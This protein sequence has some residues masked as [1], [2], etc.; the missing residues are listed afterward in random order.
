MESGLS[1]L[2]SKFMSDVDTLLYKL[3][4]IVLSNKNLQ[5]QLYLLFCI[6]EKA[7]AQIS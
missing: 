7:M 4:Y 1:L 5:V 6:D 3:K 2:S